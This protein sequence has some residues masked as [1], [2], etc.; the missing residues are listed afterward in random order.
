MDIWVAESFQPYAFLL[1]GRRRTSPSVPTNSDDSS[2]GHPTPL[3]NPVIAPS[4][5]SG[6]EHGYA[7][8]GRLEFLV[9]PRIK[10]VD[11]VDPRISGHCLFVGHLKFETAPADIRWL[12]KR[13]CGVTALSAEVRGSGCC[14]VHLATEADE[15]AVRT[16]N[17]R[18]LFDHDGVWFA[19]DAAAT[20]VLA[21]YVDVVLPRRLHASKHGRQRPSLR[22]PR[23]T[24]VVEEPRSNGRPNRR[25]TPLPPNSRPKTASRRTDGHSIAARNP[26]PPPYSQFSHSLRPCVAPLLVF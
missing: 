26:A 10:P 17:G 11:A 19:N 7:L 1:A 23:D 24:L 15:D 2:P 12:L 25:T 20:S 9:P 4:L 6:T 22:L 13:L 16:L 18:V 21:D 5:F 8:G 3:Q 14:M